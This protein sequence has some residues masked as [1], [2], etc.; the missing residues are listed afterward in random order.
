MGLNLGMCAA[1]RLQKISVVS[2]EECSSDVHS[3]IL[4]KNYSVTGALTYICIVV[5]FTIIGIC[6]APL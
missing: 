1:R 4:P 6:N 3:I 2:A 5:I